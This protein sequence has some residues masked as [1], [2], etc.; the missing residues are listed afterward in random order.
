MWIVKVLIT[1]TW[2]VAD[3]VSS[4]ALPCKEKGDLSF[5]VMFSLKPCS[6]E[7]MMQ[8]VLLLSCPQSYHS[9]AFKVISSVGN[10]ILY[11]AAEEGWNKFSY[12]PQIWIG[13]GE[14]HPFSC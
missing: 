7:L 13:R 8:L 9:Y 2:L 4:P 12:L 5:N 3:L 1:E 14:S 10:T 6:H 11:A